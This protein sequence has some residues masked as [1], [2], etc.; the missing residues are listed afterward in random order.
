MPLHLPIFLAL[1]NV[2]FA[3]G[4]DSWRLVW[5]ES[6]LQYIE[7][8]EN[9]SYYIPGFRETYDV[10]PETIYYTATDMQVKEYQD[11]Y[12]INSVTEVPTYQADSKIFKGWARDSGKNGDNDDDDAEKEA[13]PKNENDQDTA[14]K[15]TSSIPKNIPTAELRSEVRELKKQLADQQKLAHRQF[16]EVKE[17][18]MVLQQAT[19]PGAILGD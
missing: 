6:R 12:D 9:M 10:F 4:G 19:R 17:M 8:A 18:L 5:I 1:I 15:K 14:D 11:K 3:K 7:S 16:M 2:A 13:G